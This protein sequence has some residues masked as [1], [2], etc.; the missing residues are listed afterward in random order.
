MSLMS[1]PAWVFFVRLRQSQRVVG[2]LP[3]ILH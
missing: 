3:W 1:Q 2:V